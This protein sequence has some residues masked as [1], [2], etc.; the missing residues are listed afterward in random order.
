MSNNP[1]P[2]RAATLVLGA[3]LPAA[4]AADWSGYAGVAMRAFAHAPLDERQERH[5]LSLV[6]QPE[7]HLRWDGERQ[8]FDFAPFVRFDPADEERSHADVRELAW[9]RSADAWVVRAGVRKV[10]W[11]ITESQHLVD[12]INQTDLVENPD[13]EDKLGQP[14]V[15]LALIRDWGALDLFVLAGFRERTFP[16]STGRLRTQ[17]PVDTSQMRYESARKREHVDWALRWSHT[18]GDWGI[19]LS[20]FSGTGR[21]PVLLLPGT[22]S[23]GEPVLV[24]F[25]EQIDQTGL[26]LQ[27][28]K[29]QWL[30][31]LEAIRWYSR[32]ETYYAATAG[33]EYTL[34]GVFG[35]SADLGLLAEYLYDE[36]GKRAPVPY[37]NDAFI[38]MRLALNDAPS[39]EVLL[40][41]LVDRDSGARFFNLE[42]SRRFGQYWKLVAEARAFAGTPP[43]DPLFSLRRDDYAQFELLR[44]F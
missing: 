5:N 9:F 15:N 13:G 10:F 30:W 38:G 12:V 7:V 22:G 1:R 6:V 37:Q 41:V 43:A 2:W 40:G 31:K 26:D 28:T 25:Y 3:L 20:H 39:S 32:L 11:G 17:P 27:A 21:E 34:V 19:G 44:Y 16:G 23:S 8:G 35:T 18:L 4:A 33:F 29:G 14:M 24:P 36:R 42:A